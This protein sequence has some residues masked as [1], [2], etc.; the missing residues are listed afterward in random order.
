MWIINGRKIVRPSGGSGFFIHRPNPEGGDP[1]H[2]DFGRYGHPYT[3]WISPS[4]FAKITV[5]EG[6]KALYFSS[7]RTEVE[8]DA[9]SISGNKTT[10]LPVGVSAWIDFESRLPLIATDGDNTYRFRFL[11]P[12]KSPLVPPAEITRLFENEARRAKRL[13]AVPPP[14]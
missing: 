1:Y 9:D 14:P 2:L 3:S 11:P 10:T 12:P 7:T 8:F 5:F 4:N 13:N 6:K